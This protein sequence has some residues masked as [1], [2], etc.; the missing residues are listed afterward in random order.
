MSCN[1]NLTCKNVSYNI[2][3]KLN[4][5][6]IIHSTH[7]I[8][9]CYF[10]GFNLQMETF[11]TTTFIHGYIYLHLRIKWDGCLEMAQSH[12]LSL[13]LLLVC[14]THLDLMKTSHQ[15]SIFNILIKLVLK[16]CV[17]K[18]FS[19]LTRV[20]SLEGTFQ[21]DTIKTPLKSFKHH[22]KC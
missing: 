1:N 15:L 3:S 13:C 9:K 22:I 14:Q 6:S 7:L 12:I 10:L 5:Y 8:W 17:Y 2:K 16:N 20:E 4:I 19:A 18:A 11:K 21:Y